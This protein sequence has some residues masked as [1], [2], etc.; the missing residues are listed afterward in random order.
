[1]GVNKMAF[2]HYIITILI[3][4]GIG[5]FLSWKYARPGIDT[6]SCTEYLTE[7]GYTVHLRTTSK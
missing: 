7:Q 5:F 3:S 6:D 4:L 1:V 2:K